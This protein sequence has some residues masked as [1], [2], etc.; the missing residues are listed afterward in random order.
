M[1]EL[2]DLGPMNT[3]CQHYQALKFEDEKSFKYCHEGKIYLPNLEPHPQELSDLMLE[4]TAQGKMFRANVRQFNSTFSFSSFEANINPPTGQRPP[5]FPLCVQVVH[6][7]G[8]LH[9][10]SGRQHWVSQLY[11]Y[12]GERALN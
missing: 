8:G 10:A 4:D 5:Y 6:R 12:E 3:P 7:S 9:P 1:L 2:H 11:I